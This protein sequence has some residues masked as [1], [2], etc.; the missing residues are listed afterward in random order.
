[1]YIKKIEILTRD[2]K[3]SNCSYVTCPREGTCYYVDQ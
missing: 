3:N 2:I 1:M